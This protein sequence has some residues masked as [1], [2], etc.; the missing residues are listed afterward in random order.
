[1]T[2][3]TFVCSNRKFDAKSCNDHA[4]RKLSLKVRRQPAIE[5]AERA[6]THDV[7]YYVRAEQEELWRI[8]P[9]RCKL[10]QCQQII[11]CRGL[12]TLC[13]NVPINCR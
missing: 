2:P 7:C 11:R 13:G 5:V 12:S 6:P 10:P 9:I 3:F 8:G 1:M 4:D